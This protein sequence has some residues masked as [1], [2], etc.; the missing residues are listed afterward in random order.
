MT[1]WEESLTLEVTV[2]TILHRIIKEIWEIGS[3]LIEGYRKLARWIHLT[4]ENLCHGF[5]TPFARIPSLKDR[6]RI[7]CFRNHGDGTARTVDEHHSL[8]SPM[9]HLH[10]LALSLRQLDVG[11]V[12]T[13]ETR[14][15]NLHLLTLKTRRDSTY[16]YHHVSIAN[17]SQKLRLGWRIVLHNIKLHH[18]HIGLL[19]IIHLNFHRLSSLYGDWL[20]EHLYTGTSLPYIRHRI[21]IND[22]P[23]TIIAPHFDIQGFILFRSKYALVSG[24][25]IGKVHA[26]CKDGIS[27]IA[28]VDRRSHHGCSHRFALHLRIVPI[29]SLHAFAAIGRSQEIEFA[30]R[31]LISGQRAGRNILGILYIFSDA[32]QNGCGRSRITRIVAPLHDGIVGIRPHHDYLHS[33]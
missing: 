32:L 27:A 13:L 21:A 2:G 9:Q 22:E 24:R 23:V 20:V 15:R 17:L 3:T 16:E 8:A 4:E 28:L 18:R 31:H 30:F 1:E 25:E 19:E 6:L 26:R 7:L 33:C 11:S 12:A 14:L 29:S 5:S 10:H